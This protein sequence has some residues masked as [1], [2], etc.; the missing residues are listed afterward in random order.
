MFFLF[1]KTFRDEQ[2][3]CH[4]LVAAGLEARIQCLLNVFPERPA[5]RPHNHA[6]THRSVVGQLRLQNQLVVPL[7]KILS[8]CRKLFFGHA[9]VYR[10]S[11]KSLRLCE[12][13]SVTDAPHTVNET[14]PASRDFQSKFAVLISTSHKVASFAKATACQNSQRT[15]HPPPPPF[16]PSDSFRS[17]RFFMDTPPA[18][19][20]ATKRSFRSPAQAWRWYS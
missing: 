1:D 19:R 20:S 18:G 16:A 7:R 5:V 2:R 17:W 10:L 13:K 8:A 15:L 11:A 9:A 12:Q 14:L 6:A 4:V 3:K